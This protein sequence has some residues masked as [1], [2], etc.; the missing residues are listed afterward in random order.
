MGLV[1]SGGE[2]GKGGGAAGDSALSL[3]ALSQQAHLSLEHPCIPACPAR[4]CES[5]GVTCSGVSLWEGPSRASPAPPD[6]FVGGGGTAP[7]LRDSSQGTAGPGPR[8][9]EPTVRVSHW[10]VCGNARAKS[11]E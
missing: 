10:S 2:V 6:T 5:G 8:R 11:P 7:A 3:G 9:A 4:S 1:R